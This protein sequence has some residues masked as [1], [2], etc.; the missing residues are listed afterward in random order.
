MHTKCP[1][2]RA[3]FRI[4]VKQFQQAHG[5]VRCGQCN[6][7]FDAQ[8][9][10]ALPKAGDIL[11]DLETSTGSETQSQERRS[12]TSHHIPKS[13]PAAEQDDIPIPELIPERGEDAPRPS[14]A[15]QRTI[16]LTSSGTAEKY[17]TGRDTEAIPLPRLS[18]VML[19]LGSMA[20]VFLLLAQF[21]YFHRDRLSKQPLLSSIIEDACGIVGCEIEPVRDV[22]RIEIINRNVFSHP[23]VA[24]ALMITATFANVAPFPQPYPVMQVALTDLQ[25]KIVAARRFLP[26][27]YLHGTEEHSALMKPGVLVDVNVAVHDPQNGAM[28]FEFAFFDFRG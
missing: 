18:T 17:Q 2:C 14:P 6:T 19:G 24:D 13:D 27:E 16:A 11:T 23:S 22:D 7:L 9:N 28:A 15:V 21:L 26:Q 4:N 5:R 10:I 1:N 8:S 25:G 3:L 12:V 20:L